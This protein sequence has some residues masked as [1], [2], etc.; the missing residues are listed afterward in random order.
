MDPDLLEAIE[1]RRCHD[2]GQRTPEGKWRCADCQ[3]T[4]HD[5]AR[6]MRARLEAARRETSHTV[7]L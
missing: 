3:T 7:T 6:Q 1:R 5:R 4:A 2:C